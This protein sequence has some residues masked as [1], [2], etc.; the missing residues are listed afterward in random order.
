M[1]L[2]E[3]LASFPEEFAALPD[4]L[5]P[6]VAPPPAALQPASAKTSGA[7]LIQLRL[8]IDPQFWLLP[9]RSLIDL[10]KGESAAADAAHVVR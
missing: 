8:I 1:E 5:N 9:F 2:L 3:K 7:N 4:E 10:F 6:G